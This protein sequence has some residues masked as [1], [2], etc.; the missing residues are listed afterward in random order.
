MN[1][2]KRAFYVLIFF[3]FVSSSWAANIELISGHVRAMPS[4]VPNTAAYFKVVNHGKAVKLV[5]VD[6]PVAKEAQ[7]HTLLDDNG[8]IKMRQVKNFALGAH[9][10]LTLKPSGDHIMI[11]GLKKPLAVG[12]RVALTL[13]FSDGSSNTITLPVQ[14]VSR[15]SEKQEHSDHSH[16]H[17]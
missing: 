10:T 5:S 16:H 2:V 12:S 8:V 14:K 1:G 3:G 6:T 7:L 15:T 11:L 13:N 9:S 17:H 4:S